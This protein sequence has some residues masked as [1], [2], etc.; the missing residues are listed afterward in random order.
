M[1]FPRAVGNSAK[2]GRHSA[3]TASERAASATGPGGPIDGASTRAAATPP[4]DVRTPRPVSPGPQEP[5]VQPGQAGGLSGIPGAVLVI[6][7][8][9]KREKT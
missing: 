5:T 6:F 2:R 4:G 9:K 1:E 3:E 8:P 7:L